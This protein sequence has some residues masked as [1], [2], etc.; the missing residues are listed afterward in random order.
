M[1]VTLCEVCGVLGCK[2]LLLSCKNCD[3]AAVHRYCLDKVDFDGHV[4]GWSCDECH[5]RHGKV[6]NEISLEV[7]RDDKTV[8]GRQ[9]E[10]HR[11]ASSLENYQDKLGTHGSD[12]LVRNKEKCHVKDFRPVSNVSRFNKITQ[13]DNKGSN[14]LQQKSMSANVA[15]PST[16]HGDYLARTISSSANTDGVP[17]DSNCVSSA[18]TEIGNTSGSSV[19]LKLTGENRSEPSVLLDGAYSGSFS[20]DSSEEKIIREA[21]SSQM[22]HS[23]AVVNFCKDNPR[24]RRKLSLLDDDIEEVELNTVQNV[25]NDNPMKRRKLILTDND[26]DVE[27]SNTVQNTVKDNQKKPIQLIVIDDDEQEDV[28]NL[29]PLSLECEGTIGKHIVDTGYAEESVQAGIEGLKG[30]SSKNDRPI[31]DRTCLEADKHDALLGSLVPQSLEN[32]CPI[33]KRRRY[34]CPSDD[35]EEEKEVIKRPIIAEYVLND[36]ANMDSH[37]ADAKDQ[38]LQSR[39]TFSSDFT[40]HQCNICSEHEPIWSGI[41]TTDNNKSIMLAAHL[42]IKACSKVLEFA[43]SLQPVVEVIKLPRLRVWPKRWGKSGPTDDSIGLFFFPLSSRPNE[44]LDRLVKEVI[45]SDI[46]LKA[47]LG[48]VEL[49]I[50]A[51]TLLP[52]QYHEFQGKY[53]LWGMCKAR[54]YNPDTAILVEEQNGL[55]SASKEE[56]VEEHQILNQ[57]YDEWLDRK[58]SVVKH[59][60][61]QLQADC[62]NEAQ[63]GDMRTSLIEEGSVSSHSYLSGNRLRPAKDGS[64]MVGH[65]PREPGVADKQEQEEQDFTS[66]PRWNHK[67]ATIPPNDSLPSTATLFGFVTARSERCQQLIDEM[68]KEGALIFSVPEET[69]IAGSTIDKN[70]GVE[71]AQAPDNGCQQTQELRKPIEF[72]PIDHDD[73]DAASEACLELFPV[74]EQIGLAPGTD[75]K[76][77]ELDLSLGASR[78]APSDSALLP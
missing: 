49:L 75:V 73:A 57:Q 78:R 5:P 21:S 8:V 33:K 45:E 39:M 68:V 23:D 30:Q 48:P 4:I 52:E 27:L 17:K 26:A 74:R 22:E 9:S 46:V 36:V 12:D 53:Y 10:N 32:T 72:V 7:S 77:V 19:K 62:N 69:T 31:K 34:I 13:L 16:L 47:V 15:Q 37:P 60:E 50:F 2:D 59:A 61:D 1:Q 58:S 63:R 44:E 56:E 25:V 76:E 64:P 70:N 28:K 3:G 40:K 65:K 18:H 42:S 67:N 51:S 71:E 55:A 20:K 66:L 35:D 24:K 54:K 43:R 6:T 41:F 29:N 11:A 14:D 38:H